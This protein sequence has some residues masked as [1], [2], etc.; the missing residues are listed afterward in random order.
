MLGSRSW[1]A[2]IRWKAHLKHV[3]WWVS[4]LHGGII[5]PSLKLPLTE[6]LKRSLNVL[7]VGCKIK[8]GMCPHECLHLYPA[9]HSFRSRVANVRSGILI[10]EYFSW[11]QSG[12]GAINGILFG[13]CERRLTLPRLLTFERAFVHF[14]FGSKLVS[15][16]VSNC[17]PVYPRLCCKTI[18]CAR[19][20]NIDSRAGANAQC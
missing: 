14:A 15:L 12:T 7:L 4:R 20:S 11:S 3:R 16:A 8:I 9:L 18:F 6:S 2:F 19:T 17:R 5:S 10:C 13:C 1:P